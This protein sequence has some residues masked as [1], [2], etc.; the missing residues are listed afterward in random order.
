M[1]NASQHVIRLGLGFIVSQALRAVA[2]LEI[3]DRLDKGARSVDH[4]AAETGA[5]AEALY[6]IMRVLASEG[7]FRESSI[8]TF[9][10]TELGA[11]LRAD[12]PFSTRD[13]IRMMNRQPYLAF[14]ELGYSVSTGL[15]AFD[16]VF[17]KARFN[18]LAENPE[19]AALFQ[20]AMISLSQGDNEAVAEAFD[21]S[22]YSRIV[23]VGGGHGHLLSLILDR[24]SRLSGVLFDRSSGIDAARAR[25]GTSSGRTDFMV[26]DFFEAVPAAADVYI[27]KRVIHDWN[28]ALAG[29]ILRNCRDAMLP[30]G[31]VLIVESIVRDG[32][33]P[34]LMKL[35]DATM[36]VV[37]GGTE[38]TE[39]EYSSLIA[40]AGLKLE[41]IHRTSRPICILEASKVRG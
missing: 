6:R 32:D 38:R 29:K 31:R 24:N 23:D 17:G 40:E 39:A 20:R 2:D 18:W 25:A 1:A 22:P 33:E 12:A 28:S 34:D 9:E 4:L 8:R 7:I 11:T 37:T 30:E 16:L 19:D 41:R 26:G 21:F 10:L 36:L 15:P 14:S 3:A 35:I 27:L 5:D 13:M